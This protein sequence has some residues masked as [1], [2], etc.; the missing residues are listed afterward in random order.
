METVEYLKDKMK[1]NQWRISTW[2]YRVKRSEILK[3][4]TDAD[5]ERLP[6]ET[7]FNKPHAQKR[8]FTVGNALS[9]K[10]ARIEQARNS[11]GLLC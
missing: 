10:E 4:G 7:R 6:A 1:K 9:S 5:K 11:M 8:S 3:H 2:S